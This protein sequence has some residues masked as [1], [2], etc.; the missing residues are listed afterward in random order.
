MD[1]A[2]GLDAG[3][4]RGFVDSCGYNTTKIRLLE[5]KGA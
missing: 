3:Q 4:E 5:A 1:A 2:R